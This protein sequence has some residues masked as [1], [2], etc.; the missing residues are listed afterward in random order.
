MDIQDLKS[1]YLKLVYNAMRE[2][3]QNYQRIACT[4]SNEL[5]PRERVYCYELYHQ[6]RTLQTNKIKSLT[7]KHGHLVIN[8]EIDKRGHVVIHPNFNPDFVI[9]EQ[10]TMENNHC[11]IE[12]KNS[13]LADGLR[14]D[15]STITCLMHCYNYEYGLL[16]I[17][18]HTYEDVRN[19]IIRLAQDVQHLKEH[20]KQIFFFIQNNE[21]P[22]H[23]AKLSEWL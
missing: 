1:S 16:I 19:I 7:K 6:M 2:V 14:K 8:G 20:S 23:I 22:I 5:V 13:L 18:G 11:V 9:H 4:G 17:V 21:Q 10:E 3:P 12:V 15:L